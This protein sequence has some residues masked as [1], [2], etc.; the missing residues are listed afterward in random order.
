MGDPRDCLRRSRPAD[1]ELDG[2]SLDRTPWNRRPRHLVVLRPA[3]GETWLL[4]GGTSAAAPMVTGTIALLWALF[5]DASAAEIRWA[6]TA[7]RP[8]DRRRV[9]PPLLDARLAYERLATSRPEQRAAALPRPTQP[10]LTARTAR[11]PAART[12]CA[13]PGSSPTTTWASVRPSSGSPA[14][15]ASRPAAA[16]SN[17]PPPST[18]GCAS[19]EEEELR[20][21]KSETE[22]HHGRAA[23][24]RRGRRAATGTAALATPAAPSPSASSNDPVPCATCGDAG[25]AGAA[26]DH[27]H[28]VYAVGRIELRFP[29]ASVEKEYAQAA[30]RVDTTGMT[31][32]EVTHA[33]LSQREHRYLVRQM[34]W[35]MTIEGLDTYVV[36]PRD[37]ADYDLLVDTLRSAPSPGDL[38]C[39]I[40]V[41]GPISPPEMCGIAVPIVVIDQIY[42]FDRDALVASIPKPDAITAKNFKPA[43]AELFDRLMQITD[44]AGATDEHRALNDIALRYDA[45]YAAAA[46][47]FARNAALTS[48]DVVRVAAR[49][50]SEHR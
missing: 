15:S 25:S 26:P 16:A 31:D 7:A 22:G 12:G 14:P 2:G 4:F 41:L 48:V 47:A 42:S 23:D 11:S 6:V 8:S 28:Y 39:V 20:A 35:V 5:P 50:H 27:L 36:V 21:D 43:A 19:R 33:V 40:G 34:C 10:H 49:H 17:E 38:D 9:V 1:A 24:R 29:S 45:I 3:P 13:C 44:N 37:P 18:S 30:G 32:S 46:Q